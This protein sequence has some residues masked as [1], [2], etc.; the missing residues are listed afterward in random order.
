MYN[1]HLEICLPRKR[2]CYGEGG[3]MAPLGRGSLW[4]RFQH[5]VADVV[6]GPYNDYRTDQGY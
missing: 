6:I 1:S 3:L 2:K 5:T 4:I